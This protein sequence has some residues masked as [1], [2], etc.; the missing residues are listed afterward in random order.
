M[1]GRG[2]SSRGGD[3]RPATLT[4]DS[5]L[6]MYDVSY[7][8]SNIICGSSGSNVGLIC[9]LLFVCLCLRGDFDFLKRQGPVTVLVVKLSRSMYRYVGFYEGEEKYEIDYRVCTGCNT[10]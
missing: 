1:T 10:A 7:M 2:I 4:H 3:G 6:S 9:F 5:L 8:Q